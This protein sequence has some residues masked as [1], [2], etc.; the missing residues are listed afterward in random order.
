MRR[1]SYKRLLLAHI[2]GTGVHPDR[3]V[4]PL[5]LTGLVVGQVPGALWAPWGR[6]GRYGEGT[7]SL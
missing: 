2:L 4:V 6:V 1:G 5:E 3:R 7:V